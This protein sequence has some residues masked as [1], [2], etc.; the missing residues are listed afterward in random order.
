MMMKPYTSLRTPALGRVARQAL[1]LVLLLMAMGASAQDVFRLTGLVT[2]KDTKEPL[3]GVSI[4]D[5]ETRRAL[6]I[7]DIDGRFADRKSTSELQSHSDLVCRSL[8][9][10]KK[11][12]IAICLL[13]ISS[14]FDTKEI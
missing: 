14:P 9:E 7:T 11:I 12:I 4:T 5:P 10:K 13:L 2:D 6:A 3:L 8:L 1:T